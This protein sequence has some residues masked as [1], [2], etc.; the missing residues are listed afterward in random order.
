MSS[1][2]SHAN[3]AAD[4]TEEPSEQS[5]SSRGT[6]MSRSLSIRVSMEPTVVVPPSNLRSRLVARR[7]WPQGMSPPRQAQPQQPQQPPRLPSPR[8]RQTP[9]RERVRQLH[10]QGFEHEMRLHH[11]QSLMDQVISQLSTIHIELHRARDLIEDAMWE[12]RSLRMKIVVWGL[13][14]C[15]LFLLLLLPFPRAAYMTGPEPARIVDLSLPDH[16]H[17]QTLG[18]CP[19][20]LLAECCGTKLDVRTPSAT[21]KDLKSDATSHRRENTVS[22]QMRLE[23]P[24]AR[25]RE[26]ARKRTHLPKKVTFKNPEKGEPSARAPPAEVDESLFWLTARGTDM[27]TLLD[28]HTELATNMSGK[29]SE[30]EQDIMQNHDRSSATVKEAR[31]ARIQSR[32]AIAVA[33]VGSLASLFLQLYR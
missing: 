6:S 2:R 3:S 17:D 1:A 25:T 29:L 4:N 28:F 33:I 26:N 18:K 15:V 10:D 32:V 14:A 16:H 11:H 13:E 22:A 31:A 19:M 20:W 27:K 12:I 30:M 7:T 8:Q 24:K 9:L 5:S 23:R 21:K